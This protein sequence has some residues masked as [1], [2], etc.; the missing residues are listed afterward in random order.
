[1]CARWRQPRLPSLPGSQNSAA[2]SFQIGY[3]DLLERTQRRQG[4]A[5]SGLKPSSRRAYAQ[6][7]RRFSSAAETVVRP[8][9]D[10]LAAISWSAL[11]GGRMAVLKQGVLPCRL[12]SRPP[13]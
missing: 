8:A 1:M 10:R 4:S 5:F 7:L 9:G 12:P 13:A 6:K 3:P 2:S 11:A